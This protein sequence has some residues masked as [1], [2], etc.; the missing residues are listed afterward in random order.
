LCFERIVVEEDREGCRK[1]GSTFWEAPYYTNTY[2][3]KYYSGY[4]MKKDEMDRVCSTYG[5]EEIF[6]KVLVENHKGRHHLSRP[7]VDGRII[8]KCILNKSCM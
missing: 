8:I 1:I 5:R 3:I 2:F 6:G 7:D 4:T